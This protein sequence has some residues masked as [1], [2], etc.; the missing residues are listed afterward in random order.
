MPAARLLQHGG[1][2]LP[3]F[4]RTIWSARH[5]IISTYV[6]LYVNQ[7]MF[8]SIVEIRRY[9]SLTFGPAVRLPHDS[10]GSKRESGSPRMKADKF[11]QA[12]PYPIFA[13]MYLY[14]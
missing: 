7:E 1:E 10:S 6:E 4:D 3:G 11:S 12:L 13:P 14:A 8:W 5:F 9:H 2:Q